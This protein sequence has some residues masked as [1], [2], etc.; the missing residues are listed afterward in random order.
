MAEKAKKKL[1]KKQLEHVVGGIDPSIYKV[2]SPM[3]PGYQTVPQSGGN[4]GYFPAYGKPGQF[5]EFLQPPN[6][7]NKG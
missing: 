2:E 7:Q 3:E 4:G 1:T 5:H 6:Q